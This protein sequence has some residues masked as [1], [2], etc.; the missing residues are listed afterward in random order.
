V[1]F[2]PGQ[3]VKHHGRRMKIIRH[4]R[5]AYYQIKV[6]EDTTLCRA[7]AIINIREEDRQPLSPLEELARQA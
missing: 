5:V 2:V 6:L 3:I 4:R 7:G 1:K